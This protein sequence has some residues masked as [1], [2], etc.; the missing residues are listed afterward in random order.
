MV[1]AHHEDLSGAY[2]WTYSSSD[3]LVGSDIHGQACEAS[4]IG[5]ASG[6][7]L[8]VHGIHRVSG[9][10]QIVIPAWGTNVGPVMIGEA[11][12]CLL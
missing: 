4:S 5:A 6:I 9:V 1:C 11:V 10:V 2:A 3:T 7:P 12:L 8:P